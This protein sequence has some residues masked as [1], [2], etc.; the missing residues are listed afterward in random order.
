MVNMTAADRF[1]ENIRQLREQHEIGGLQAWAKKCG[2]SSPVL[3]EIINTTPNP[4]MKTIEKLALFFRLPV[5]RLFVSGG[6]SRDF[7]EVVDWWDSATEPERQMMIRIV[8]AQ[9]Q[10]D[11]A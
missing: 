2:V 1:A 7:A 8:R 6:A 9:S 4:T 5:W 10:P 11:D 3:G